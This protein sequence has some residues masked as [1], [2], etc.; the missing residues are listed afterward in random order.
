MEQFLKIAGM[1]SGP[2]IGL[3]IG[4]IT[5]YI[6]VKMLFRPLKEVRVFGLRLPFT[7]GII[8][9]RQPA[10]AHAM[11]AMV[12]QSL[13][14]EEDLYRV[15][16]SDE[17]ADVVIRKATELPVFAVMGANMFREAYPDKREKVLDFLEEK[18][19]AAVKEFDPAT[20]VFTEGSAALKN[21]AA[22][23][24]L[25][26]MFVTDALIASFAEPVSNKVNEYLDTTGKEKLREKLEKELS[27]LEAKTPADLAGGKEALAGLIRNAYEHLIG[28]FAKELSSKFHLAEIVEEKINS[29]PAKELE[30]LVLSVM[31]KE[32]NAVI[33][34]GGVIGF[35]LGLVTM[36]INVI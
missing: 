32:L 24:P 27:A 7:P 21:A 8:P 1:L 5:N 16:L 23:N 10:L 28:A 31:K 15:F 2:L 6:A 14:R 29:M 18:I 3:V 25:L 26:R 19:L 9:R 30:T 17:I 33:W 13:V 35:V 11:G 12:G 4:I 22:G 34:L 36:L 20:L